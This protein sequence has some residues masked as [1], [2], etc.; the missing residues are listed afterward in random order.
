LW[1]LPRAALTDTVSGGVCTVDSQISYR[2]SESG[3]GS[4]CSTLVWHAEKKA[5]GVDQ[6]LIMDALINAAGALLSRRA[7]L[8]TK[9]HGIQSIDCVHKVLR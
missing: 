8:S 5:G 6:A 7:K 9:K 4:A 1:C 2:V 3:K